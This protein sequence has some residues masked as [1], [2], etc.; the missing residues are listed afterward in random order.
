ML[1]VGFASFLS[2][3]E[4]PLLHLLLGVF[5]CFHKKL[6]LLVSDFATDLMPIVLKDPDGFA[7]VGDSVNLSWRKH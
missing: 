5:L 3:D 4:L 7:A 2:R 6:E 1:G